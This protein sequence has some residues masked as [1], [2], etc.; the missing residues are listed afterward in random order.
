[1][2]TT[3]ILLVREGVYLVSLTYLNF[4]TKGQSKINF[5]EI[6]RSCQVSFSSLPS[7]GVSN[8]EV[9]F[10][11]TK[12]QNECFSW[13]PSSIVVIKSDMKKSMELEEL[14]WTV[15]LNSG[16]S[17]HGA[18]CLYMLFNFDSKVT[19]CA[20]LETD[21]VFNCFSNLWVTKMMADVTIKIQDEQIQVHSL[22]LAS[23]SPVMA[24][25]FQNNFKESRD[26]VIEIRDV[27][28]DVMQHLLRYIYTGSI[29]LEDVDVDSLLIAADKYA[30]DPLKEKCVRYIIQNLSSE[31]VIDTLVFSHLHNFTFIFQ[32]VLSY[33]SMN[34]H[35]VS[36]QTQWM[37]LMKIYPEL[38]FAAMQAMVKH[39]VSC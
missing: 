9:Q 7:D 11:E 27:E 37:D 16:D 32:S 19:D 18:K 30:V 39:N 4:Y 14:K 6:L 25:M 15:S 22:I 26:K 38:C 17:P 29:N 8:F 5:K 3:E 34:S 12:R 36:S 28:P 10:D 33:M 21:R 13:E 20:K 24:A 35:S 1:M 23:G 2:E 31:N